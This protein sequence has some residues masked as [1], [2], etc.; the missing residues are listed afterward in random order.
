M[1]RPYETLGRR[2]LSILAVGG[3]RHPRILRALARTPHHFRRTINRLRDAGL[4][5]FQAHR[6]GGVWALTKKASTA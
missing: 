3:P 4:V 2:Y 1:A 6:G 5:R